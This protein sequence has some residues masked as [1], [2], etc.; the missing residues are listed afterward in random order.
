VL[1]TPVLGIVGL[2]EDAER[3]V[4]RTVRAQGDTIILLGENRDELG[5]SEY[6]KVVHNLIRG[7]PPS[8][9]LNREAS[10]QRVLIAGAASGL[11]RSAHDCSEGGLAITLAECCFDTGLGM[12]AD[13]AAIEGSASDLR[14]TA[15]LFGEAASRAVVTSAPGHDAELLE[16]A[17][18]EGVPA[19]VM[20]RVGGDRLRLSIDGRVVI[21]EPL[22]MAEQIWATG[23][24]RYFP[25]SRS[26]VA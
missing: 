18:R 2:I 15:T 20:G 12:Q 9:D 19:T 3:V 6:L 17:R 11:I 1:P 25:D 4:R 8:L 24:D 10:L 5:G 23:I 13:L 22:A 14:E 26:A 16:L 7:V 21:D